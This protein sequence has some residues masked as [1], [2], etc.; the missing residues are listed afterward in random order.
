MA[1]VLQL[2]NQFDEADKVLSLQSR[3]RP[4]DPNLWY[5]LAEVRGLAG[6]ILG[7]H[8]ARAEYFILQAQFE[9]AKMQ[10]RYAYELTV[11]NKIQQG[12][13]KQRLRDI[14]DMEEKL[15]NL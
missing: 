1:E 13:I 2:D 4:N 6:N 7:V 14:A 9:R 15:K 5:Q 12:R 11:S 8:I 3:Q 10:L